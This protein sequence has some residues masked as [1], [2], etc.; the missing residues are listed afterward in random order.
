MLADILSMVVEGQ[1]SVKCSFEVEALTVN[2]TGMRQLDMDKSVNWGLAKLCCPLVNRVTSV[3]AELSS[4]IIDWK[5]ST[6]ESHLTDCCPSTSRLTMSVGGP[7]KNLIP[8]FQHIWSSLP[9]DLAKTVACNALFVG[10]SEAN[11]T[12][13]QRVQITLARVVLRR[14]THVTPALSEQ[15]VIF[16]LAILTCKTKL[17]TQPGYL[18][19]L[20]V[21]CVPNRNLHCG[22][23]QLL[24]APSTRT[25]SAQR[26]FGS[27]AASVWNNLS[28][29]LWHSTLCSAFHRDVNWDWTFQS[30][31]AT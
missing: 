20:I 9:D 18:S 21:D 23:Q 10:V 2:D 22:S 31:F 27:S 28:A 14:V 3:S 13:L 5:A 26:A 16:K 7:T 1:E 30:A 4:N 8:A 29:G 11:F 15:R 25:V 12:E 17:N 6:S 19:E 24:Q